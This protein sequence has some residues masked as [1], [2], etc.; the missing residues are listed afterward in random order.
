MKTLHFDIAP[1]ETTHQAALQILKNKQTGKMFVGKMKKSDAKKWET[2]FLTLLAVN[3]PKAPYFSGKP[4][5]I[6]VALFYLPPKCRPCKEIEWKTTK[7]DADNVVKTILDCLVI[8][9]YIEADQKIADLRV[10]KL[11]WDKGGFTEVMIDGCQPFSL[12]Q[13]AS[14]LKS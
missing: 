1:P 14:P 11:E 12:P 10:M 9:G 5:R 3:K 6:I 7:P 2:A 13:V 8:A 4:L